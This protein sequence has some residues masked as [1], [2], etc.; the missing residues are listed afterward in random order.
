MRGADEGRNGTT[1]VEM[2]FAMCAVPTDV[3]E[4]WAYGPWPEPMCG[5]CRGV[6]EFEDS[7]AA[8]E[9]VYTE[10]ELVNVQ[11]IIDYHDEPLRT[12][13][14]G[15]LWRANRPTYERCLAIYAEAR[16]VLAT[17]AASSAQR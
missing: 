10:T 12:A 3:L 16:S 1:E 11:L 14:R 5:V 9:G 4:R 15:Q 2:K 17:H 7:F 8:G 13:P 6:W